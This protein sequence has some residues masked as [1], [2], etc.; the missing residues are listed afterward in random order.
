[1]IPIPL[2]G[3]ASWY[4]NDTFIACGLLIAKPDLHRRV[5]TSKVHDLQQTDFVAIRQP[6]TE[7][8]EGGQLKIMPVI[9]VPQVLC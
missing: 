6:A 9:A 5:F 7:E 8:T 3:Y 2:F 1:M 4:R